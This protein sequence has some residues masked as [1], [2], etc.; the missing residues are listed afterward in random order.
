MCTQGRN[1]DTELEPLN[2]S[3]QAEHGNLMSL[4]SRCSSI[5][6]E[7]PRYQDMVFAYMQLSQPRSF[8]MDCTHVDRYQSYM[9]LAISRDSN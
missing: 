5:E 7:L 6:F 1:C 2:S 4:P 9:D 8:S 3:S